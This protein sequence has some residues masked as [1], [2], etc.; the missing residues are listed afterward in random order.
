MMNTLEQA[1]EYLTQTISVLEEAQAREPLATRAQRIRTL[2]RN[3]DRI[4]AMTVAEVVA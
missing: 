1:H 4:V 3:L 2:N